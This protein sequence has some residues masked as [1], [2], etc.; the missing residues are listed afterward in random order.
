MLAYAKTK[1]LDKVLELH[2]EASE[3]YGLTTPG[4]DRMNS[5]LLAYTRCGQPEQGERLIREMRRDMGMEPDVVCYTTLID[6][7]FKKGNI[8]KCWELFEQCSTRQEPGQTLDEQLLSYM[9]RVCSK[10]KDSEMGIR[11]FN[12]M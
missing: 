5:I 6:G 3:K 11:L 2:E 10:T 4:L 12:D 1:N 9:I 7:Y 8:K